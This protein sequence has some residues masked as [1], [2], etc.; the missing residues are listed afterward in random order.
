MLLPQAIRLKKPAYVRLGR[1]GEPICHREHAPRLRIGRP[2]VLKEGADAVVV[3][4]GRM[5]HEV[6]T[7]VDELE[8]EKGLSIRV[9]S[10]H[11]LKPFR[12][13]AILPLFGNG[14]PIIVIEEQVSGGSLGSR[15]ALWLNE[16]AL[17]NPFCHLHLPE[18]Y[19]N[20]CGNRAYLLDCGKLSKRHIK[21]RMKKFLSGVQKET[22]G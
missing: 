2:A 18:G 17:R 7:A 22:E 14:R 15:L 9:V 10:W 6:L 12:E 21:R 1:S 11:T 8:R 5:T 13:K 20:V 4:Y 16:R 19:P 3:T